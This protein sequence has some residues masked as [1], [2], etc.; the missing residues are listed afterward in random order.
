MISF[1]SEALPRVQASKPPLKR[2]GNLVT[3]H[4][5]HRCT[6]G[7]KCHF[8]TR[9]VRH[10]ECED[11]HSPYRRPERHEEELM[12][13]AFCPATWAFSVRTR[14]EAYRASRPPRIRQA[15]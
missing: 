8:I 13:K 15:P 5:Y 3:H 10:D 6:R 14:R 2:L 7:R 4:H 12:E 1:N 11:V 9:L